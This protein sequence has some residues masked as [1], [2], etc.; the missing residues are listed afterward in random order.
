MLKR[1][2]Q[3]IVDSEKID[4]IFILTIR[5]NFII[6]YAIPC[7]QAELEGHQYVVWHMYQYLQYPLSQISHVKLQ[8][9]WM[10]V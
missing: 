9:A 7:E 1:I 6:Y 8:E 10:P 2:N 3:G 4:Q 5:N